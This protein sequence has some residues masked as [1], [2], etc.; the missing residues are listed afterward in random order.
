MKT[1]IDN[2][3]AKIKLRTDY[4]ITDD[5]LDTLVIDGIND[6]IKVIKQLLFDHGLLYAISDSK[7]FK[8]IANQ[9]YRDITKAVIVGNV[10]SFTG[11]VGD[12][13][14]VIID[15]TSTVG[16][17]IS[18][19]T[20]IADVVTAINTAVGFT[21]ASE[22]DNGF[23]VITS[24]VQGS[25]SVVT[26][27]PNLIPASLAVD[28]L[29]S[30][31]A[32][33]TQSAITDLE[34]IVKIS[35]RVNDLPYEILPY[36]RFKDIYTDPTADASSTPIHAAR[37]DTK[38]FF[39][40][41]TSASLLVY[42]DYLI[43]IADVSSGGSSPFDIKYDPLIIAMGREELLSF[44]DSKDVA[45]ITLARQKIKELK[46]E[47]IIGAAKNIGMN[48]QSASR[49]EVPDINPRVPLS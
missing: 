9:E 12:K 37:F 28:R 17:D 26:I 35:D 24:L 42:L 49:R 15:G 13:I 6:S 38:I 7:T 44:L 2:L 22:D 1:T 45:S 34:D 25:S 40:P 32:E 3:V 10:A 5:D 14:T 46:Q 31:S 16:I 23:L 21:V 19:S 8:T 47:L 18:A 41:R 36:S 39:G 30:V 27:S 29:F 48:Q 20:S 43:T 4:K 33:R 11:V